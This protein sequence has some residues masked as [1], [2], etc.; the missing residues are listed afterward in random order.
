M[1]IRKCL[2]LLVSLGFGLGLDGANLADA[3][4]SVDRMFFEE[5]ATSSSSKNI[6]RLFSFSRRMLRRKFSLVRLNFW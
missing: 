6:V 5:L 3:S 1:V 4:S 2:T